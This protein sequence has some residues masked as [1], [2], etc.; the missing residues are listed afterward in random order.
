MVTVEGGV[1]QSSLTLVEK[2][3]S[4]FYRLKQAYNVLM[5]IQCIYCLQELDETVQASSEHVLQASLGWDETI[6]CVCKQCNS[7]F[8]HTLDAP[9]VDALEPFRVNFNITNERNRTAKGTAIPVAGSW[10]GMR[11]GYDRKGIKL[12]SN[13]I[14]TGDLE[15]RSFG[16]F[17]KDALEEKLSARRGETV[18]LEQIGIGREEGEIQFGTGLNFLSIPEAM[19]GVAKIAFNYLALTLDPSGQALLNTIYDRSRAFIRGDSTLTHDDLSIPVTSNQTNVPSHRIWL[20]ANGDL[21][22]VH[23]IIHFFDIVGVYVVMSDAYTGQ[24]QYFGTVIDPVN[25]TAQKIVDSDSQINEALLD[26]RQLFRRGRED[27]AGLNRY[28]I[29]LLEDTAG[30]LHDTFK[31]LGINYQIRFDG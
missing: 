23:S 17:D 18:R 26:G 9:L 25:R 1:V 4:S 7:T 11:V 31:S 22:V 2:D 29:R 28:K 27:A 13:V 10:E 20:A 6:R 16:E 3:R 15:Y 30:R 5:S 24:N 14:S 8:G 21:G 12:P 19:R